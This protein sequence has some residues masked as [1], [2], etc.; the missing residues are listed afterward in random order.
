MAGVTDPGY[1]RGKK[2]NQINTIESDETINEHRNDTAPAT[3]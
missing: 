1:N 3:L 2:Q